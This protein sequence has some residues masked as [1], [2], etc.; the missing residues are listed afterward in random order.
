MNNVSTRQK[1]SPDWKFKKLIWKNKQMQVKMD[2]TGSNTLCQ[3][4]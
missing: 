4:E 3:T 1:A 2:N